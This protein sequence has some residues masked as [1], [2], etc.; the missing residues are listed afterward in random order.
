MYTSFARFLDGA[1]VAG[2]SRYSLAAFF[3]AAVLAR[4]G[5]SPSERLHKRSCRPC[6]AVTGHVR[7]AAF[8]RWRS[9]LA[10]RAGVPRWRSACCVALLTGGFAGGFA[11][12]VWRSCL[13]PLSVIG[14]RSR[15]R[16]LSLAVSRA[17]LLTRRLS[18]VLRSHHIQYGTLRG[19]IAGTL[20]WLAVLIQS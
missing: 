18:A 5:V 9:A 12:A 17:F 10:F 7:C 19:L 6:A 3:V 14:L 20:R 15:P 1:P 13:F 8:T 16:Y 11:G 2:K 4:S